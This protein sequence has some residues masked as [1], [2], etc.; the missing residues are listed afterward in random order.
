MKDNNDIKI[1][2]FDL[3]FKNKENKL[4]PNITL[5]QLK[6]LGIITDYYNELKNK[7]INDI[8]EYN[9]L[10]NIFKMG[11]D[12]NK[13]EVFLK[14]PMISLKNTL[15]SIEQ[16]WDNGIN[17]AFINY[18]Y[19]GSYHKSKQS[20][21]SNQY[22]HNL[23]LHNG[24]N[25]N[26]WRFRQDLIYNSR[27]R[28]IN[29]NQQYSYRT[30]KEINSTLTL[31]DFYTYIPNLNTYKLIGIQLNNDASM[32]PSFFTGYAPT[33]KEVANTYADITL[34]KNG[35]EIYRTS[36]PPGPFI[37]DQIPSIGLEGEVTLI[38]KEE[39]NNVRKIKL[40]NFL[41]P[42][43][44]RAKQWNY[45]FSTGLINLKENKDKSLVTK[46][47]LSYGVNNLLTV[48]SGLEIKEKEFL[49][50]IGNTIGLNSFGIISID[51]NWDKKDTK[52]D[53]IL[54]NIKYQ[55]NLPYTNTSLSFN[56]SFYDFKDRSYH[57]N[58]KYELG[59][60]LSQYLKNSISIQSRYNIASYYK[61]KE[62]NFFITVASNYKKFSYSI[63]FKD[64][65]N[66]HLNHDKKISI[67]L[68]YPLDQHS[69]HWMM[70]RSI[71]SNKERTFYKNLSINGGDLLDHR[72]NYSIN[73][74]KNSKENIDTSIHTDYLS[75]IASLRFSTQINKNKYS[76]GY[77]ISGGVVFH[78]GGITLA[79]K[80][81]N[82]FAIIDFNG[83]KKIKNQGY[84]TTESDNRGYSIIPSLNSFKKNTFYIDP[85][86]LGDKYDID[87]YS[88]HFTPTK[89]A[90]IYKTLNIKNGDKALF[91]INKDIPFGATAY[92]EKDNKELPDEFYINDNNK[93]YMS[94]LPIEGKVIIKWGMKKQNQ[95]YFNYKLDKSD[96][97]NNIYFKNV[98]C[99]N[100][101]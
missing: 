84:P 98:D 53:L 42:N 55:A 13:Q 35:I 24:I 43:L 2:D 20:T 75:R 51:A 23:V 97:K 11:I 96:L 99:H 65:K 37:L 92:I 59:L 12:L 88:Y 3:Y 16:D 44:L 77:G 17:A 8:I 7:N 64:S 27:D 71:Y 38:I 4:H 82:S 80:L 18:I 83:A 39:N 62:E 67:S 72:L 52:K 40:W 46:L 31:G 76:L 100:K 36:V 91:K 28:K 9:T 49:S 33:I 86:S 50:F 69:S 22:N 74:S 34:E 60:F 10:K 32:L 21:L 78:H 85:N 25:I 89:G 87:N 56:S 57:N 101:G 90:I 73:L 81:N 45:Y 47:S 94:N 68:Y 26:L 58:K 48:Y 14:V 54:Y 70:I 5:R 79:Q 1:K 15:N 19:S 6:E 41:S 66:A 93:L 95:C 61:N 30:L 29:I 63:E